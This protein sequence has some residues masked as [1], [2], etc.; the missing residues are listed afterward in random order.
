MEPMDPDF[1]DKETG[2]WLRAY[3]EFMAGPNVSIL[4]SL[5]LRKVWRY[6]TRILVELVQGDGR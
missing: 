2:T 6:P 5:S 1:T 4:V 3:W